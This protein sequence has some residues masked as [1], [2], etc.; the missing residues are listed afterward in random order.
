MGDVGTDVKIKLVSSITP[1][2]GEQETYEMWLQGTFIEKSGTHYLRYEEVQDDQTIRTTVKLTNEQAFIMRNGG[3]N[4]RLP[5]NTSQQERG[6][7]ESKFGLIP[8]MTE[9][10]QLSYERLE[11][12]GQFRTEYELIID[13]SSVGN[14]T[15]EIN[16]TEV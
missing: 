10:N 14:Y 5:L 9:T 8:L 6:R 4:M 7:Y 11:T 2:E 1:T 13:G 12:G 16:Y 3:I 15:L